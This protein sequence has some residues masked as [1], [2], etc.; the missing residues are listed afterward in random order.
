MLHTLVWL[1]Q[2]TVE[3]LLNLLSQIAG[4]GKA[5]CLIQFHTLTPRLTLFVVSGDE[6]PKAAGQDRE[7]AGPVPQFPEPCQWELGPT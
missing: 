6:H 4:I 5:W 7:A 2:R 3:Y 1:M